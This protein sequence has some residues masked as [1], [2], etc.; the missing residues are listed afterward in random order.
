MIKAS[1][2][3]K[4]WY[5]WDNKRS[6]INV[7]DKGLLANTSDTEFTSN[8]DFL[9]NGVKIRTSGSGENQSGTNYIFMAFA[10]SPFVTSTKIPTTA[11]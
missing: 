7:N 11:R 3:T 8:I 1:D 4:S 5:M 6:A 2:A 9:S 10:E